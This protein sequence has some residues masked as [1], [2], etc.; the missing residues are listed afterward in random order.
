NTITNTSFG[1]RANSMYECV[2]ADNAVSESEY[3]GFD[4][5]NCYDLTIERNT[6]HFN[7]MYGITANVCDRCVFSHNQILNASTGIFVWGDNC[8][9]DYNT[10]EDTA[11]GMEFDD[12][13]EGALVTNN[14]LE[15]NIR[16]VVTHL[17]YV[18][19]TW[20]VFI[21]NGQNAW[22]EFNLTQI[23][24][25]YNYWSDYTGPDAD[26]DGIGDIPY[27]TYYATNPEYDMHP[28]IYIP[29]PPTWLDEPSDEYLEYGT[30]LSQQVS[31]STPGQVAPVH[32]WWINTTGLFSISGAGLIT[33]N[34][35]L[36]L[37]DYGIEVRAY[38]I[39]GIYLS[40]TFTVT[41]DDTIAPTLSSP[42]D[43]S[44]IEGSTGNTI[45]W[46][47]TDLGP[48]SYDI[49]LDGTWVESG[50]WN[51]SGEV[52][53]INC[54]GLAVGEHTYTIIIA[55]IGGNYASDS[56][57]VTVTLPVDP[58]TLLIIAAGAGVVI[59]ILIVIIVKKRSGAE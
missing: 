42:A 52:I 54:D 27:E 40:G 8:T 11:T 7:G 41:V 16:G 25:D 5:T 33:S 59:V 4:L 39:Y 15:E 29:T 31:V 1:L 53:T 13:V 9:L 21:Q 38:N 46:T 43:F 22:V 19:V 48:A 2:I 30:A 36:P 6:L 18:E 32:L 20:N 56:V 26:G 23:V 3:L 47:A 28:L 49:S 24:F 34:T 51:A 35:F 55:D 58:T 10:I 57:T 50:V 45:S 17:S 12:G 14:T 44:F 37:G